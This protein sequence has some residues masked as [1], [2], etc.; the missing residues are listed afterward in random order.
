MKTKFRSRALAIVLSALLL[1]SSVAIPGV[2]AADANDSVIPLYPF[3]TSAVGGAFAEEAHADG[4]FTK[5][6]TTALQ[7][8]A[9]RQI[10]GIIADL[11]T[12]ESDKS[13]IGNVITPLY[14]G[15]LAEIGDKVSLTAADTL[16]LTSEKGFT[17]TAKSE[18]YE[19]TDNL[20]SSAAGGCIVYSEKQSLI[21]AD[22]IVFY[23]KLD[24]ANLVNFEIDIND[25]E[26]KNRWSHDWDP[27]LMLKKGAS[28]SYM[29]V[30]G[31][32]WKSA[33]AVERKGSDVFGA[34]Q[35]DSAFEGYVKIPFA[36]LTND[37]GF[38]FDAR[39]DSVERIVIR[40][41]A[42]GGRYGSFTAGPV[43]VLSNDDETN[44]L[45]VNNEKAE[46]APCTLG[47]KVSGFKEKLGDIKS[48]L[49][50]VKTDSANRISL[51]ANIADDFINA[52][53][54]L[55][56]IVGEKAFILKKGENTFTETKIIATETVGAIEFSESFEGYVKIPLGSFK[57]SDKSI[58]VLPEID[59]VTGFEIGVAGLGGKFGK[60]IAAPFLMCEDTG[61]VSFKISEDYK[62]PVFEPI[63]VT[64]IT[65]DKAYEGAPI[66]SSSEK[67]K[68][69]DFTSAKG[70]LFKP[71]DSQKPQKGTNMNSDVRFYIPFSEK[72]NI[73]EML[74]YVDIP[75]AN[76]V[77]PVISIDYG[78]PL[79]QEIL[80]GSEYEF[81]A[82]DSQKWS[83]GKVTADGIEFDSAFKGYIKFNLKKCFGTTEF[84]EL[85]FY[86][87]GVGTG[88]TDNNGN[89]TTTSGDKVDYGN[90]VFGPFFEIT[91][92]TASTEILVS[93]ESEP[94]STS[95]EEASSDSTGSEDTS[96]DTSSDET[97]VKRPIK[98]R[99]LVGNL[100]SCKW[101]LVKATTV[102]PLDFTNAKGLKLSSYTGAEVSFSSAA[103]SMTKD[104]GAYF[105]IGDTPVKWFDT[106]TVILYVNTESANEIALRVYDEPWNELYLKAGST[107]KYAALGSAEWS[108]AEVCGS[109]IGVLK[110]DSAFKGY[111]KLDLSENLGTSATTKFRYMY[112]YLK[113][114]GGAYGEVNVAP[115]F[116][117]T[118]DGALTEII[119]PD[120]FKP[121]DTSSEESS[122]EE[123]S[124]E[125]SSSDIISSEES[126]SEESS[127]EESSSEESSSEES[128]SEESS[129]EESSSEESSS[130]ESS[131]E[132]SS[133]DTSS[134]E[135]TP[136]KVNPVIIG[137]F[138]SANGGAKSS[139]TMVKPLSFTELEGAK[140][141]ASSETVYDSAI[142]A[143]K[144][145]FGS[146]FTTNDTAFKYYDTNTVIIYV[147]TDSANDIAI[148]S[149]DQDWIELYLKPNT[150]YSY[151][152]LGDSTW[153]SGT[154]AT[155]NYEGADYGVLRFES[156]FEGY[157]KL[158][159]TRNLGTSSDRKFI[160]TYFYP[161]A[162]G[163]SAG[164]V[165]VGPLFSVT[166]EGTST[167]LVLPAA[168][169][170]PIEARPITPSFY[171]ANGNANSKNE[172]VRPLA[173]TTGEGA[174][175]SAL[176]ET[177]YDSAVHALKNQFGS[178]FT[179]NDEAFK[180]YDSDTVIIYIKTDSANDI[181]MKM[182]DNVWN[183][184]FIKPNTTY[185]YA[186]MGDT[187]WSSATTV[188][189][190]YDG[191]DYGVFSFSS[192][193]EGYIKISLSANFGTSCDKSF[194]YTY[195]APKALGG[196]YGT[197]TAGPVFTVTKDSDSTSIKV[198]DEY[199]QSLL[200]L[201]TAPKSQNGG[202]TAV[203]RKIE[204]ILANS[205]SGKQQ[206][207]YFA[208]GDTQRNHLGYPV[209][210]LLAYKLLHEYNFNCSIIA[211]ND[212]TAAAWSGAVADSD[213]KY[214]TVDDLIAEISGNGEGVIVD[215]SLGLYD[216]DA[217]AAAEYINSAISKLRAAKPEV[218]IV[219]TTGAL[220]IDEAE[221]KNT[222]KI[223]ETVLRDRSIFAVDVAKDV[224]TEY[225]TQFYAD[226]MLPNV[227]GYRSIAKYVASKYFGT[228]FEK[229]TATDK[230][231]VALP[232]G[233]T[234]VNT[235]Y[236]VL[237][238]IGIDTSLSLK[239]VGN[240]FA[241]ALVMSGKTAY[242]GK[243]PYDAGNEILFDLTKSVGGDN[244]IMFRLDIPAANR[245]G[246]VGYKDNEK[247]VNEDFVMLLNNSEFD[248]LADGEREWKT[249]KTVKG[250]DMEGQL[251]GALDIPYAFT[252]WVRIPFKSFGITGILETGEGIRGLILRFS[253]LGGAYGD[254]SV[255]PYATMMRPSYIASGVWDKA[256]LPEMVPFTDPVS[257]T[258]YWEAFLEVIPSVTPTLTT[259][260]GAWI[261][262]DPTIDKEGQDY[263]KSWFELYKNYDDMPIGEFTH[264]M[265]Y[266]KVPE[267]KENRL[268]ICMFTETGFE[269]KI[270][271]NQ[272]YALLSLG[273]TKWEH[274]LAED[275]QL[276][277]Y[278]G[279]V[280]PAG[281][282]GFIK[283][284]MES[285]LPAKVNA[286]TKLRQICFRFG[287]IGM[288][289]EACLWG[290]TF[291]VT[292]DNDEGPEE[293][294]YT[295]LPAATTIKKLFQIEKTD[296]FPDKIMLY[297]Q[298]LENAVSYV[299]EAYSVT[300]VNKGYE[301]RL[302]SSDTFFT[303][304]G[305]IT[306]L[307]M[308]T[309]YAILIKAKD[310]QGN[311]IATYEYVRVK[312][313]NENPY[314]LKGIS[315]EVKL[316]TV[317]IPTV[318]EPVNNSIKLITIL[319][320]CGSAAVFAAA[321]IIAV[322]VIKKK[323]RK[324]NV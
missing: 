91:K 223:A 76:K 197:V 219:Y 284:P 277:N 185:S 149:Y 90:I 21:G 241:N 115:I 199:A 7:L 202:K 183:E 181:S 322:I 193:F 305:T 160:Y 3:S 51:K 144:D 309:Q 121:D 293:L 324:T 118:E 233:A 33:A 262:C 93:D 240:E 221:N 308:N 310:A 43:F 112:F 1:A 189:V 40:T 102:S 306:G 132:E 139:Q 225:Y 60:V 198:P 81:A 38:V 119:V 125:E 150:A 143:M 30:G 58:A 263:M 254:V 45:T 164:T 37:S 85:F 208:I 137:S 210:R 15:S 176:S 321:A 247:N 206:G 317:E 82:L 270:M 120:E 249:L 201:F 276:N 34:M 285:L 22:G 107:Y 155:V 5:E 316:D 307:E 190:N 232:E 246:I 127:S 59:Y 222:E 227:E 11:N 224:F 110:F 211:A 100:H 168:E 290:G 171:S 274:Y 49:L 75:S 216:E 195:F 253:E 217:N 122:S 265:F 319:L 46:T 236:K 55:E 104:L 39:Q 101:D 56:L 71:S 184:I 294:V 281:F 114:L 156:A 23:L 279:I 96:S 68:P 301:Y 65:F 287:Y 69:L 158:D 72:K 16:S 191:T 89:K 226:S 289:E 4:I 303:N 117:V 273:E 13:Y 267:T 48:V 2:F 268:S 20:G 28:Y 165:T 153:S 169:P 26:N 99:P 220:V 141:S 275:V 24:S 237:H 136:T 50:Y 252:G 235:D 18:A 87:E 255:G 142:H 123:S 188:T 172:I 228:K 209:F 52:M 215:I 97:E 19:N 124:S 74:I 27:W 161:K 244:C 218:T 36:S 116:S 280:L 29:T 63:K 245:I 88:V 272:P 146:Y 213:K 131:S 134:E 257:V 105:T 10:N 159:L 135:P 212:L 8:S 286:E 70:V 9:D 214:P 200:T 17:V 260:V 25:P 103:E 207:Y 41:K 126:S 95:S 179:V 256:D 64:P 283:V 54:D 130:E 84:K 196:E 271:A 92:N 178:Y 177:A 154:T 312:T 162:L 152:K 298:P 203:E 151:A 128:S 79:W 133:S 313:A 315:D 299:V 180:Y 31:S 204:S 53:P 288:N 238:S 148:K 239:K 157:V 231:A 250:S 66:V 98:A 282:E 138:H 297:W 77:K 109:D 251:Q 192:A 314:V 229:I 32:A 205:K 140:M 83:I 113:G 163:T 318:E 304:S 170:D 194:I 166:E 173:F 266:V 320:I 35:F 269:F 42:V 264:L 44:K 111:I 147:K 302:V 6:Y 73:E 67:V 145:S 61:M 248:L 86:F 186:K 57:E 311:I 292:R 12:L 243:A 259:E 129:S 167:E 187:E 80:V 296:I 323:R 234:L 62:K 182:F 106:N 278:G 258:K 295:A 78:S 242:S 14:S 230:A 291:G 175:M 174:K 300:R 108:T 94:D 47:G 261:S